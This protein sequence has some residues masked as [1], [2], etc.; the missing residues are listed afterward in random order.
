MP[1]GPTEALGISNRSPR[2]VPFD[3][4]RSG[5][6]VRGTARGTPRHMAAVIATQPREQGACRASPPLP[7]DARQYQQLYFARQPER[8]SDQTG[9]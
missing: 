5:A 8:S 6:D 9:E 7:E 2:A 1:G 4:G 3:E